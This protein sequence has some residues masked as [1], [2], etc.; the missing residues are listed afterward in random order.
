MFSRRELILT[1]A[2]AGGA[3]WLLLDL[4]GVPNVF[5]LGSE[6]GLIPLIVV[7]ALLA[8]TRFRRVV[9]L[10]SLMLICVVM[11]VAYTPVIVRPART[12]IRA[13]PLPSSADAVV[14]LSAGVTPDGYLT[15]QG[16]DRALKG[17]AL[18]ESGLAPIIVFTLEEKGTGP[19]RYN[20]VGDQKRISAIARISNVLFTRKVKSTHDE[21]VAVA[22]IARQRGWRR[23]ALVTSPFHTRRACAT[24]EQ[25]GLTVSCVPSESRDIAVRRLIYPHDRVAA[26]GMWLYETAGTLRY[27]QLGWI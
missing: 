19:K 21:A 27:R 22:A 4:L 6:A 23:I 7:G 11:I 9:P 2:V 3:L 18:V 8:L 14:V 13:D 24:F 15:Q 26:F 5:G 10:I 17:V 1:G 16:T 25:T 20:S 12:F